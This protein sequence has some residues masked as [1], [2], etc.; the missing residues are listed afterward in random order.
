ML[1]CRVLKI[2]IGGWQNAFHDTLYYAMKSWFGYLQRGLARTSPIDRLA[3]E[4]Q[5]LSI[6]THLQFLW[7]FMARHWRAGL[8]GGGLLVMLTLLEL[9]VPLV[10]RYLN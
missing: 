3:P 10:S 4:Q 9:P 6:W 1:F 5:N 7:P 8:I 2:Y